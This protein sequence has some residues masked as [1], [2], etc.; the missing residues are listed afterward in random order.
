VFVYLAGE[1]AS[2]RDTV[3]VVGEHVVDD[4]DLEGVATARLTDLVDPFGAPSRLGRDDERVERR[5]DRDARRCVER[6]DRDA[7]SAS[8]SRSRASYGRTYRST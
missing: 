7:I 8:T 4:D 5:L 1:D 6:S 2:R 3:A